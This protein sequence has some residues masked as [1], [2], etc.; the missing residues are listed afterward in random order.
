MKTISKTNIKDKNIPHYFS[1]V[2]YTENELLTINNEKGG[3]TMEK[4]RR[5]FNWLGLIIEIV[6]VALAFIAGDAI[7]TGII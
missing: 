3:K 5:K 4:E 6:K 1:G 2:S 7:G